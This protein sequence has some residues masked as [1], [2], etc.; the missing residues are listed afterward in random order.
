M[1]STSCEFCSVV[2][3]ALLRG[4]GQIF[5]QQR[6][7][8]KHH[9]GLWEFPGGK[10]D[11]GET[12]RQALIREIEEELALTLEESALE[13]GP[14]AEEGPLIAGPEIAPKTAPKAVLNTD[15]VDN[16]AEAEN[17][18]HILL[19]I[20]KCRKWTG[21]PVPQEGQSGDWFTLKEALSLPLA[22]MDRDLLQRLSL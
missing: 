20:Y 17:S 13:A 7:A 14:F 1:T 12:P 11:E 6:P 4:N 16:R 3:V 9:G 19:L 5:L 10:I 18:P 2:A 8:H 21:E 22:P 15:I